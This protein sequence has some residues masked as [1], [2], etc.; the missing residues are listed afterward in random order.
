MKL[1]GTHTNMQ[2]TKTSEI[3]QLRVLGCIT[4]RFKS[5]LVSQRD[6]FLCRRWDIICDGRLKITSNTISSP[7]LDDVV[8]VYK[9]FKMLLII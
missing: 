3:V 8:L 7:V 1:F 2:K 9:A 6:A 5:F 4:R